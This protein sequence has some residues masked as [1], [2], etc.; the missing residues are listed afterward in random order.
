[1]KQNTTNMDALT[2]LN[3][4]N[5]RYKHKQTI[6]SFLV[7]YILTG[8]EKYLQQMF[9]LASEDIPTLQKV[10]AGIQKIKEREVS[11]WFYLFNLLADDEIDYVLLFREGILTLANDDWKG[12][13][14][15]K[16]LDKCPY[17]HGYWLILTN[18]GKRGISIREVS[19]NS[20]EPNTNLGGFYIPLITKLEEGDVAFI[21]SENQEIKYV[22]M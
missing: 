14:L 19:K 10:E 3:K 18:L 5:A 1:M 12:I 9:F 6:N 11:I 17:P 22:S 4:D 7:A 8:A 2:Q 20:W 13:I 21:V 16:L 15:K